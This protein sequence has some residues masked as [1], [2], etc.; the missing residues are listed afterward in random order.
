MRA[1][2]KRDDFA[3][4]LA[5]NSKVV[6]SRSTIPILSCVL[7]S[8]REDAITVRSTNLDIEI[9]TE[10]DAEC[11]PGDI[12]VDGKILTDIVKKAP[13]TQVE[14]EL[15]GDS[16]SDVLHIKSGSARYKM[17]TLP[18]QDFPTLAAA[19]YDA[20]FDIDLAG[21]VAPVA[22]AMSTEETRFFLNGVFLH[23]V[24]ADDGQQIVAVATDGHRLALNK[25]PHSTPFG[26]GVIVPRGTIGILPEG[27]VSVAICD[28]RIRITSGTTVISS[29][30]VDGTFPD[31]LRVI[32][33]NNRNRFTF[34]RAA[35]M[36]AADRVA[37]VSD[38]RGS[39]V[40]LTCGADIALEA[41]GGAEA[42]D[43][44][45]AEQEGDEVTIG[46]NAAYLR[47][48]L[49]VLPNG[50]VVAALEADSPAVFTSAAM[51]EWLAVC[52]PMRVR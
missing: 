31:Y 18:A 9:T 10:I 14:L 42:A 5:S 27:V 19:S 28:T 25:A 35:M 12:C 21:L 41:R 47:D 32:P 50:P 15:K 20:E 16:G 39:A 22:Y 4:L 13:G 51:P 11:Q 8:A 23:T 30:L 44:V 38:A 46:F 34:D 40:K 45:A 1:T 52:M 2:I 49:A 24:D 3:R 33:R 7:L 26:N 43:A 17:K 29:K 36:K 48:T 6:E 37:S